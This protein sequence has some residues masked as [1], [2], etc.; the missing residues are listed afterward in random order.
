[1][2]NSQS[3]VELYA[4]IRK[5]HL[6]GMSLRSLQR[7]HNVTWRTV[8]RALDGQWP[9]P[10]KSPRRKESRLD[11]YKPLIDGILRADL[12]APPKQRHT[13]QRI[14]DRLVEGHEAR[15]ISCSMVRLYV[16][17]RRKEIRRKAG[18]G[19]EAMFGTE[20]AMKG[21]RVRYVLATK[22]VNELVE[23]ADDKQLTMTIAPGTDASISN[24][25]MSSAPWNWTAG[26]PSC[27]SRC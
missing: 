7:V 2:G 26:E 14:F 3:K 1:M 18:V 5:D 19:P 27:C 12:D 24:A 21:F 16:Q 9:E 17:N 8:R 25:S 4:A 15:D 23:A 13:A 10:R 22:L 6:L 11:P 20:A